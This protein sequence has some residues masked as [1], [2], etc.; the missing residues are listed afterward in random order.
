[1]RRGVNQ[2]DGRCVCIAA[3]AAFAMAAMTMD[4]SPIEG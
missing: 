4:D 1:M 3:R 2:A